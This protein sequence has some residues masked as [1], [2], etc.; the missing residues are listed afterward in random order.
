MYTITA[1]GKVILDTYTSYCDRANYFVI[2]ECRV[3]RR[4]SSGIT[5]VS[6]K[7]GA[8]IGFS[9]YCVICD[10]CVNIRK[11]NVT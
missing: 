5:G 7:T 9:S 8:N 10:C 4:K 3:I 11:V 6:T 2:A 1:D